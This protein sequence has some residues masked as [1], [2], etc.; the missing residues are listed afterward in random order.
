[1]AG[2][3]FIKITCPIC[4]MEKHPKEFK[5]NEAFG[6]YRLKT[7]LGRYGTRTED[8][9]SLLEAIQFSEEARQIFGWIRK[10]IIGLFNRLW[11][12]KLANT[13]DLSP[14]LRRVIR[15]AKSLFDELEG[16]R[17]LKADE[18]RRLLDEIEGQ[19]E[20][21]EELK[22]EIKVLKREMNSLIEETA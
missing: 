5:M 1:M 8:T 14:D 2:K 12:L 19:A 18:Y 3:V 11:E 16:A 21:N 10:N 13:D 9:T 22:R 6:E 17:V 15:E 7:S 20:E 4:G